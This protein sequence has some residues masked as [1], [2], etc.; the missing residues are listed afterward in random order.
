MNGISIFAVATLMIASSTSVG[1]A[2]STKHVDQS[3][4]FYNTVNT[5]VDSGANLQA[6]LTDQIGAVFGKTCSTVKTK[7]QTFADGHGGQLTVTFNSGCA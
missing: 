3:D 7:V 5:A 4:I 1:F 2:A 6:M